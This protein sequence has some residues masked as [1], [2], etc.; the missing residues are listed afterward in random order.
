MG[1]EAQAVVAD[2]DG[3]SF[4]TG[5]E[6]MLKARLEVEDEAFNPGADLV[7]PAVEL[8]LADEFLSPPTAE[9]EPAAPVPAIK[10]PTILVAALTIPPTTPVA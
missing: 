10:L 4:K 6:V 7:I 5:A 1:I 9:I 2:V 8:P 3:T